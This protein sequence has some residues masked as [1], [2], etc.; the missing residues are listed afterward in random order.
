MNNIAIYTVTSSLHDSFAVSQF[1]DVFLR[2]IFSNDIA[3]YDFYGADFSTIG[4]H[5]LDLIYIRTGGAEGVFKEN[6]PVFLEKGIRKFYLLTSG[7]SNSLAASLEILSYLKQQGLDG[8]VLHGPAQELSYRI[9]TLSGAEAARRNLKGMKIGVIGKPSDWLIASQADYKILSEKL[10]IS[11]EDIP[12]SEL[13]EA[14]NA[15]PVPADNFQGAERILNALRK[16]VEKH[17]LK[18]FTLRC[19]DLLTEVRN[20]GCLALAAFNSTGIPAACE[21]DVPALITMMI[22]SAVTGVSGFQANPARINVRSGE[23]LFAHCTVPFNMAKT[24][25][26]TTHFESG[27]GVGIHGELPEGPVTV[28]KVAGDLSRAFVSEGKLLRNQY[29]DN[30]CRTQV[31]VQLPPEDAKYFLT[32]PIGNHHIIIPGQYSN[33]LKEIIK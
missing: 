12:M 13:I 10:G 31:I 20:T 2:S 23:I 24:Y 3:P 15:E 19:F 29:E 27:L 26:Y 5:P 25:Q 4:S 18:A 17:Q 33:V 22:T 21:G 32:N 1:S 16:I 11:E 8:E 14:I 6:L 9:F 30:L 28:F 7:Q